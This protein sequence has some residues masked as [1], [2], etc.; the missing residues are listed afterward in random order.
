LAAKVNGGGSLEGNM[1]RLAFGVAHVGTQ[2]A[3]NKGRILLSGREGYTPRA[4]CMNIKLNELR[5]KEPV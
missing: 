3:E 2:R 5:Q 1:L 4:S